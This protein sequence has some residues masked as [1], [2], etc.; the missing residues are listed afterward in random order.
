MDDFDKKYLDYILEGRGKVN[1]LGFLITINLAF[2]AAIYVTNNEVLFQ[3]DIRGIPILLSFLL[4]IIN[5]SISTIYLRE[6]HLDKRITEYIKEGYIEKRIKDESELKNQI[7]KLSNAE[8]PD[9]DRTWKATKCLISLVNAIPVSLLGVWFV[10]RAIKLCNLFERIICKLIASPFSW[11][12]TIIILLWLF[13]Y[14]KF[15][16]IFSLFFGRA[17][18]KDKKNV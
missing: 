13:V 17:A 14:W 3:S 15:D 2:Y 4:I 5:F 8:S 10:L 1:Y 6:H 7:S 18:M 12:L 9:I 11:L 16:C